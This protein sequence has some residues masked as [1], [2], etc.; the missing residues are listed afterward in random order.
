MRMAAV[1]KCQHRASLRYPASILH[2]GLSESRAMSPVLRVAALA[3]GQAA[4]LTRSS[5][6][7]LC[8]VPG[9]FGGYHCSAAVTGLSRLR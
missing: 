3:P 6:C 2:L 5:I 1:S 4:H 7:C 8:T 9:G